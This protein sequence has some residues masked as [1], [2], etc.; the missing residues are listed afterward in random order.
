MKRARAAI[1]VKSNTTTI[2][3]ATIHTDHPFWE[4][5][6]HES[7][8]HFD[9]LA[10]QAKDVDGTMTVT[11]DDVKGL[12]YTKFTDTNGKALPWRSCDPS[13]TPPDN[14]GAL[15]FD[16]LGIPYDPKGDPKKV[17][18]DYRD[19]MTY[20]QSTQGHLNSDGLCFVNRHY[21]SPP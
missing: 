16:S 17:M 6:V 19:F 9:Q 3:Q 7:P 11:I 13:Y 18:R 8:A 21:P 2:A 12:D 20:D 5:F 10:T 4:S 15:H 14:A 1:Q